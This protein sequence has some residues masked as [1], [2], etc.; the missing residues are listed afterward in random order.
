MKKLVSP[1]FTMPVVLGRS[2]SYNVT[3]QIWRE[4]DTYDIGAMKEAVY[5]VLRH[6]PEANIILA[7]MISPTK[8]WLMRNQDEIMVN[9]KG[10]KAII[11]DWAVRKW[12]GYSKKFPDRRGWSWFPSV[13][14]RKYRKDIRK[15][16][17]DVLSEFEKTDASKAV[18][19]IYVIGGDDGQFRYPEIPDR[20]K[21]ALNSF[22]NYLKKRYK[23]DGGLQKARNLP[24]NNN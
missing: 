17:S 8:S 12:I 21:P 5:R 14:S 9:E 15:V 22:R 2:C 6:A 23:S 4:D 10:E 13:H 20:S 7:L 19:G 16:L 24:G 3:R 18:V 11:K 1:I